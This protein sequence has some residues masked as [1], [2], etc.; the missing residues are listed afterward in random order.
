MNLPEMPNLSAI[1]LPTGVPAQAT[2]LPVGA[3]AAY[4]ADEA[5]N[6]MGTAMG[7]GTPTGA[8]ANAAGTPVD[9]G[10]ALTEY[11]TD[12]QEIF[13]YIKGLNPLAWGNAGRLLAFLLAMFALFFAVELFRYALIV[14]KYVVKGIVAVVQWLGQLLHTAIDALGHFIPG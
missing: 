13:S 4:F 12:S 2:A 7:V 9:S 3:T 5:S 14:G 1:N 6:L 10:A 11:A 8:I